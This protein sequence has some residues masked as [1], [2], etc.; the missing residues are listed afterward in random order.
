MKT[1]HT[2]VVLR[3]VFKKPNS[4]ISTFAPNKAKPSSTNYQINAFYLKYITRLVFT[5]NAIIM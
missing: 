4:G 3:S 2:V 5:S 1:G